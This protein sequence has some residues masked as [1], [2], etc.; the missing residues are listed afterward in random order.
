MGKYCYIVVH[1]ISV[2]LTSEGNFVSDARRAPDTPIAENMLSSIVF[3]YNITV[4]ML[5]LLTEQTT[6]VTGSKF[7]FL[8]PH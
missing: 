4:L 1:F 3:E 8:M 7:Q 6:E 5:L 2:Y